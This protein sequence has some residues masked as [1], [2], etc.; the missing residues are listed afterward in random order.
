MSEEG[1]PKLL[2][3]ALIGEMRRMFRVEMEQVHKQIDR[4]ENSRVE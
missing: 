1:D 2:I 3:K 4:I